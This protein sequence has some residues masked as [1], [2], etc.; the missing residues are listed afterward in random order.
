MM[1]LDD[2][3][4]YIAAEPRIVVDQQRRNS[5][6]VRLPTSTLLRAAITDPHGTTTPARLVDLS[7]N[8][9]GARMSTGIAASLGDTIHVRVS[10]V[11]F[12][13]STPARIAHI[14]NGNATTQVGLE[15]AI[16]EQAAK[17]RLAQAV[18][19]LQRQIL[20]DRH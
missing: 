10:L 18:F 3:P 5:Y 14:E 13:L 16:E 6:R 8:G 1:A 4:A 11:D 7:Q 20:R 15:F 9:C 12:D 2:G 17:E 19:R